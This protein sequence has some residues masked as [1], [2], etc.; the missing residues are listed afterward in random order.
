MKLNSFK[1]ALGEILIVVISTFCCQTLEHT[2][3]DSRLIS[4][5]SAMFPSPSLSIPGSQ[6]STTI[7]SL[8]LILGDEFVIGIRNWTID[9]KMRM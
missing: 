8:N 9:K 2:P 7:Y 3:R 4:G 5:F 6:R 1:V